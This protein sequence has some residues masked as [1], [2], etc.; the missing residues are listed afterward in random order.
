MTE[1]RLPSDDPDIPEPPF[2]SLKQGRPMTGRLSLEE[3]LSLFGGADAWHF[4]GVE[5]FGISPLQVTDCGHGVT[6]VAPPYGS[7]TCFPT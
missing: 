6:L 7:A 2:H 1:P 4:Q 3:K 5:R